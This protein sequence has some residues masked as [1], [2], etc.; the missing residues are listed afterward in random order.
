MPS[1][2]TIKCP[3]C[4]YTPDNMLFVKL[5]LSNYQLCYGR[6]ALMEICCRGYGCSFEGNIIEWMALE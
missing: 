4:A 5:P 2:I 6:R 1:G 3:Q